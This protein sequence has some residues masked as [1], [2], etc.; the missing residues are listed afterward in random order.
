MGTVSVS[1]PDTWSDVL[2]I[3]FTTESYS[4]QEQQGN[5]YLLSLHHLKVLHHQI[6]SL[7]WK[8]AE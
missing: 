1:D 2:S 6:S 4:N 5:V 7:V 3:S 8:Q